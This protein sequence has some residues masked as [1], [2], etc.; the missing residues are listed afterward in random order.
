[1]LDHVEPEL[2]DPTEQVQAEDITNLDL[3]QDKPGA[4]NHH[5]WDYLILYLMYDLACAL[6]YRSWVHA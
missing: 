3:D 1:M 4:S 6:D 5:H 2:E